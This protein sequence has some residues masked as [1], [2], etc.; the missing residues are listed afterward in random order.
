MQRHGIPRR[1]SERIPPRKPSLPG[2]V[3]PRPQVVVT[4]I[5]VIL[6]AGIAEAV[7]AR[8]AGFTGTDQLAERVV[9][10]L[11]GDRPAA[12][13]QE[14]DR[15]LAVGVVITRRSRIA[16][17]RLAD[18]IVAAEVPIDEKVSG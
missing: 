3:I 4:R 16:R 15:E 13:R 12:V 18:Q 11:I 10:V 7:L 2:V 8:R 14:A 17:N 6:L 1:T 9:R 5:R